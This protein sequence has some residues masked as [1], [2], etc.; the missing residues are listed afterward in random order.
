M[1]QLGLSYEFKCAVLMPDGL[2]H[3]TP[4]IADLSPPPQNG[5][6]NYFLNGFVFPGFLVSPHFD[7]C[8]YKTKYER[9]WPLIQQTFN[10]TIGY[11]QYKYCR[12][13]PSYTESVKNL[14]VR[15]KCI[16]ENESRDDFDAIFA[17]IKESHLQLR[18][19]I[20]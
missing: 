13:R 18:S 20:S 4:V 14:L 3:L 10:F 6:M 1:K 2:E 8:G 15:I 16:C 17:E 11:K 12:S 19:C 7:F 9:Y 5:G